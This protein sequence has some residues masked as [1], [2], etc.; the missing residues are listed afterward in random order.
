MRTKSKSK[1]ASWLPVEFH[2]K[3]QYIYG[4]DKDCYYSEPRMTGSIARKPNEYLDKY[5][6]LT[7]Y[8]YGPFTLA[9]LVSENNINLAELGNYALD[10]DVEHDYYDSHTAKLTL[11]RL[12]RESNPRYSQELERYYK[13][14]ELYKT[15]K[16][17]YDKMMPLWK[18]W[19][20]QE[21]LKQKIKQFERL[22]KE[23]KQ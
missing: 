17:D 8:T 13:E 10:I 18:K 22:K 23:L 14:S 5:T 4:I 6:D 19:S 12:T 15:E 7:S 20:K 9:K 11:K 16:A 3:Y 1:F 2:K 21:Q